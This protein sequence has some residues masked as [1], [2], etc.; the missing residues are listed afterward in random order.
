MS[1]VNDK[2]DRHE[3][4]AEELLRLQTRDVAVRECDLATYPE[5]CRQQRHHDVLCIVLKEIVCTHLVSTSTVDAMN[6][7][8]AAHIMLAKLYADL[9]YPPP[10]AEP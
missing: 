4:R 8:S 10:K 9:A 5:R 2:L 1:A 7:A 3:E 6:N